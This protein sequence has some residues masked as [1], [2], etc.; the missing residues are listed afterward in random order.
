M[1]DTLRTALAHAARTTKTVLVTTNQGIFTGDGKLALHK[2]T[3]AKTYREARYFVANNCVP[4]TR[5]ETCDHASRCLARS[6]RYK[7]L[8]VQALGQNKFEAAATLCQRAGQ[9]HDD[10]TQFLAGT[11]RLYRVQDTVL[12]KFGTEVL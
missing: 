8:A 4:M 6:N 3:G 10:Y 5:D 7:S 11:Q 1:N 2:L 9:A 12:A